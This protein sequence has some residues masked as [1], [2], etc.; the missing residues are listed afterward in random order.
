MAWSNLANIPFQW[1]RKRN[2]AQVL[3]V[4]FSYIEFWLKMYSS[5]GPVSHNDAHVIAN[6]VWDRLIECNKRHLVSP[7]L[8]PAQTHRI[9]VQT[10]WTVSRALISIRS[11]RWK[12]GNP[13]ALSHELLGSLL[14]SI[15]IHEERSIIN[16]FLGETT[17]IYPFLTTI[18]F[19]MSPLDLSIFAMSPQIFYHWGCNVHFSL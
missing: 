12:C 1:K 5:N 18:L 19:A 4:F 9:S 10:V 13:D 7:S 3:E 16:F 8:S 11:S 6:I 17:F 14:H 2:K 15:E